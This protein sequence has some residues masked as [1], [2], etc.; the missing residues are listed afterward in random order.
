MNPS[1]LPAIDPRSYIRTYVPLLVGM[2]LGWLVT[3]YTAAADLIAWLDGVLVAA[4]AGVNARALLDA[5]AI[6]LVTA[7]YYWAARQ[8]GRRWPALEKWLLGSAAIPLYYKPE[9]GV[10]VE[11]TV[12]RNTDTEGN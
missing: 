1:L 11:T 12:T 6:A 10:I 9:P 8:L 7:A 4:G 5:L 3:T 2:V